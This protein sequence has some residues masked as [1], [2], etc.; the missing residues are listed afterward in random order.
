MLGG[1]FA[2]C[3]KLTLGVVVVLVACRKLTVSAQACE[4]EHI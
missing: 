4:I 2:R 3:D 1:C